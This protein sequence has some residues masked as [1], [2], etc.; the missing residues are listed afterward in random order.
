MLSCNNLGDMKHDLTA[1]H[2]LCEVYLSHSSDL[3]VQEDYPIVHFS[4]RYISTRVQK[5]Q[6]KLFATN[7]ASIQ[8]EQE[9]ETYTY[10]A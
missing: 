1:M 4:S 8:Q 7:F 6:F 2:E 5:S 3:K 10:L 9:F